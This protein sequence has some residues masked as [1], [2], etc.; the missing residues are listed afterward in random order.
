MFFRGRLYSAL[1]S[2]WLRISEVL[3]DLGEDV[4][5]TAL[6]NMNTCVTERGWQCKHYKNMTLRV[7]FL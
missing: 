1:L 3:E 6:K 2:G 7:L 5:Y 4:I